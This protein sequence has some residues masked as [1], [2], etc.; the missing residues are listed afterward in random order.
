MIY[1][2][3]ENAEKYKGINPLL[4]EALTILAS[5][6]LKDY[7]L[8]VHKIKGDQLRIHINDYKTKDKNKC[9]YEAHKNF[10]DIHYT[11][12]G[13]E[14]CYFKSLKDMEIIGTFDSKNDI[15]FYKNDER[16][17]HAFNISNENFIIVFPQDAHKPSC[18]T[19]EEG[20]NLR[21][22]V[23]KVFYDPSQK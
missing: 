10:I 13:N 23:L 3:L 6:K 16:T 14:I 2:T 21:K 9:E 8:G 1:D 22:V 12:S 17:N 7:E 5:G 18:S 15:G 19:T 11:I 20:E 4:D